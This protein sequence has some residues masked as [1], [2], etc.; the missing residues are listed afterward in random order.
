MSCLALVALRSFDST[1][2]LQRP[3]TE[4][5][6]NPSWVTFGSQVYLSL[7]MDKWVMLL[8]LRP[9]PGDYARQSATGSMASGRT[10]SVPVGRPGSSSY[11][12]A[13]LLHVWS[14]S[15]CDSSI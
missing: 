9:A 11:S 15:N 12:G 2:P 7:P 6:V 4:N 1:L 14:S 5:D 10:A 3:Q 13:G 8:G